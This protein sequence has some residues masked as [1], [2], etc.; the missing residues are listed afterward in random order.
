MGIS[1][2]Y[3]ESVA[4]SFI[5]EI[6]SEFMLFLQGKLDM[7]NSLEAHIKMNYSHHMGS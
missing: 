1:L 3:L 5:P 7:L 6:Q 4:I 2:P